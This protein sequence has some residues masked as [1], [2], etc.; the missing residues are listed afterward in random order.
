LRIYIINS[1]KLF[2]ENFLKFTDFYDME[3]TG[4]H[5]FDNIIIYKWN[6]Q[7]I[8]ITRYQWIK[9]LYKPEWLTYS[10]THS[11]LCDNIPLHLKK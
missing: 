10:G 2:T 1:N 6:N 4:I 9:V 3:I 7:S 5:A 8:I 11:K